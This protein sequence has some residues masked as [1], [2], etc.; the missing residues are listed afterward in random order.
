MTHITAAANFLEN[1]IHVAR[2]WY[3]RNGLTYVFSETNNNG[4]FSLSLNIS[5][6]KLGLEDIDDISISCSGDNRSDIEHLICQ[7]LCEKLESLGLLSTKASSNNWSA[8]KNHKKEAKDD[9]FDVYYDRTCDPSSG[10]HNALILET[11]STSALLEEKYRLSN[12]TKYNDNVVFNQSSIL[13]SEID[14]FDQYMDTL[15]IYTKNNINHDISLQLERID[16]ILKNRSSVS[17]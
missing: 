16:Y 5:S 8:W 11:W 13:N 12:I 10:A 1:P 7:Q 15:E 17:K 6:S 3:E 9:E 4:F 14:E 2:E